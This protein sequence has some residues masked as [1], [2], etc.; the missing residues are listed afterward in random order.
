MPIKSTVGGHRSRFPLYSKPSAGKRSHPEI[1]VCVC[2][3]RVQLWVHTR[4]RP[5][6]STLITNRLC[7]W[8]PPTLSCFCSVSSFSHSVE[9]SWVSGVVCLRCVCFIFSMFFSLALRIGEVVWRRRF[10]GSE[11]WSFG[12]CW[13]LIGRRNRSDDVWKGLRFFDVRFPL[14][15]WS[16]WIIL[17]K[18]KMM[19]FWG[20]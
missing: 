12:D 16:V 1:F 3:T 7:G 15:V 19:R 6:D 17:S 11:K 10:S 20:I 14:A 9:S 4:T 18:A 5:V 8:W 2:S 13:C